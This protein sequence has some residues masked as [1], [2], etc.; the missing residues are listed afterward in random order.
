MMRRRVSG[1]NDS[2]TIR[3]L[4]RSR[5]EADRLGFRLLDHGQQQYYL[6]VPDPPRAPEPYKISA[7][8]SSMSRAHRRSSFVILAE[9]GPITS[10]SVGGSPVH[11][12]NVR[13][14]MS[15]TRVIHGRSSPFRPRGFKGPLPHAQSRPPSPPPRI[16]RRF[17]QAKSLSQGNSPRKQSL[18]PQPRGGLV[19]N[20]VK[21]MKNND[22]DKWERRSG[23]RVVTT[24][25]PRSSSLKALPA[26]R[27]VESTPRGT[28]KPLV[29]S[30]IANSNKTKVTAIVTDK[31]ANRSPTKI[32]IRHTPSGRFIQV[33]NVELEK[34]EADLSAQKLP[35][36]LTPLPAIPVTDKSSS[37]SSSSTAIATGAIV[38]INSG[39]TSTVNNIINNNNSKQ[40]E[41]TKDDAGLVDLLKQSSTGSGAPSVVN[42]TT[43]TAVQPLRID[44]TKILPSQEV[45]KIHTIKEE[46]RISSRSNTPDMNSNAGRIQKIVKNPGQKRENN[47]ETVK[48]IANAETIGESMNVEA[49]IE[50]VRNDV[51][52][53]K[54]TKENKIKKDNKKDVMEMLEKDEKKLKVDEKSDKSRLD[55]PGVIGTT[56][57][58]N[59]LVEKQDISESNALSESPVIQSQDKLRNHDS[60]TSLKSSNGLSTGSVE[61]IKSTDT[62]VSLNTV[63]G[64]SSAREKRGTHVVKRTQEIETLSGNVINLE[65]QQNG[66]PA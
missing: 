7:A 23:R 11:E 59:L 40:L 53:I 56:S 43:T 50:T 30:T 41:L 25:I 6:D 2:N 46:D 9:S 10:K 33:A 44:A 14:P 1:V 48:P 31:K 38:E 52:N 21:E 17:V 18:I 64:V 29:K 65:N 15:P 8:S 55:P 3:Q 39:P 27:A 26:K 51:N 58:S 22:R 5:I 34:K 66:E 45:N 4:K 47:S 16:P 57:M 54:D 61:S 32:P 35:I 37:S 42:A 62:G 49:V 28:T 36:N 19:T 63:R 60:E 20:R 24:R 12:R 13:S